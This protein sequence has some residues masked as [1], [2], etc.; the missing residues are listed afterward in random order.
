MFVVVGWCA[1]ACRWSLCALAFRCRS[2]A[3]SLACL[4]LAR[5]SLPLARGFLLARLSLPL[6]CLLSARLSLPLA[7][8]LA[9]GRRRF[10]QVDSVTRFC[11]CRVGN[12]GGVGGVVRVTGRGRMGG[13]KR[14]FVDGVSGVSAM[15]RVSSEAV[16]SARRR[17]FVAGVSG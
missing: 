13:A 17:A 6:A 14:L 7:R 10:G 8:S 2:L 5:L 4:L 1:V 15:S 9:G 11:G 12:I 16:G 3:G